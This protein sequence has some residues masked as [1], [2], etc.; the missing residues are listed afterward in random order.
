MEVRKVTRRWKGESG[1]TVIDLPAG[2]RGLGA[3]RLKAEGMIARL[4]PTVGWASAFGRGRNGHILGGLCS[5]FVGH[6]RP[7]DLNGCCVVGDIGPQSHRP[8]AQLSG[9]SGAASPLSDAVGV[10]G[11]RRRRAEPTTRYGGHRRRHAR[12]YIPWGLDRIARHTG[13]VVSLPLPFAVAP[14]QAG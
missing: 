14:G 6:K 4:R 7:I 12:D 5:V 10:C 11:Q 3:A 8:Q 2:R 13:R 9:R 1:S